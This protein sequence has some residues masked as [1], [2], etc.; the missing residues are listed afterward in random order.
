[1]S[2][3][4]TSSGSDPNAGNSNISWPMER[5][6]ERTE[7]PP[8]RP[9]GNG[10]A[11]PSST[12]DPSNYPGGKK[13]LSGISLR[14]FCL[15]IGF[16]V[17]TCLTVFL[18]PSTT[19]WRVPFFIA[20]LCLFHFLEYYVTARYNTRHASISAFLLSANGW[21][22]NVAHG[23]AVA[24]CILSRLFLP[25]SYFERTTIIFAGI[26][27]QVLVGLALM[28]VGQVFRTLAMA[29]AGSNFNHTVQVV[30][31]E[32]HTL[33]KS[34]VYSLFRH[35]SYFGF[36]WWG[37]GSQ[38]V[39]G[40]MVC[41]WTYAIILWKFFSAR[42][43]REEAYLIHFFGEEYLEYKKHTGVGIPGIH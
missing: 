28:I 37:L 4:A 34:G 10:S 33:V 40:N 20:A 5:P 23:S 17:S 30:R 18:L 3:T 24:E 41:F 8:V 11:N 27:L 38:L 32:G 22:Y 1:M 35:P 25:E 2:N 39:L 19:L 42:I 43:Q 9:A 12:L 15:G 13:S 21:A 26:N 6:V 29:Q 16:G 31:K 7:W 36:F 14:A